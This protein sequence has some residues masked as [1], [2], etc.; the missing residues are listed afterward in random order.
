LGVFYSPLVTLI[1]DPED[2]SASISNTLAT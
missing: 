1:Q 2:T